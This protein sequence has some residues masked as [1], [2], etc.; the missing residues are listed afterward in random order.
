MMLSIDRSQFLTVQ[1]GA[2]AGER[3]QINYEVR[4]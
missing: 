3:N 4:L 2:V 1:V